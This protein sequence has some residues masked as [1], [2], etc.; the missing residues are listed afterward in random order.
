MRSS[1]AGPQSGGW[2]VRKDIA[3]FSGPRGAVGRI[4]V[5]RWQTECCSLRCKGD[6]LRAVGERGA[7]VG[8][9]RQR[10]VCPSGLSRS[11]ECGECGWAA[12]GGGP[13]R[14][15]AERWGRAEPH[16]PEDSD[17]AGLGD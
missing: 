5:F 13:Q 4:A 12:G 2:R 9:A 16:G 15:A 11:S 14:W 3:V 6:E 7:G 1:N 17:G 10:V 8:E